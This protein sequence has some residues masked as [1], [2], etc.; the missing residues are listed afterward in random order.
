MKGVLRLHN[1]A[2]TPAERPARLRLIAAPAASGAVGDDQGVRPDPQVCD[3]R[4]PRCNRVPASSSHGRNTSVRAG[5]RRPRLFVLVP[6]PPVRTPA[7][8][9]SGTGPAGSILLVVSEHPEGLAHLDGHKSAETPAA[10]RADARHV[11]FCDRQT[12][13]RASAKGVARPA[14]AA[15]SRSAR[16]AN[17][18]WSSAA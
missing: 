14:G 6:E 15:R 9:A 13:A 18:P 8:R 10:P 5:L 16:Y 4:S 2:G 11:A 7:M 3:R 1:T 12:R 17:T